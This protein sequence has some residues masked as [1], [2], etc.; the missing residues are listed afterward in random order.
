MRIG[1]LASGMDT[2]QIISD[3]MRVERMPLDK[4]NQKKQALEWQRDDYREMNSLMAEMDRFIFDGVFRQSAYTKKTVTSSNESAVTVKNI[5]ATSNLTATISVAEIAET[6]YM[7]SKGTIIKTGQTL[8]PNA[9]LDS[10]AGNFANGLGANSFE[11]QSIK[12]DGTLGNKVTISFNP[13]VDSLNSVLAKINDSEAGV[14]AFYDPQTGKVSMSAKNTGDVASDAEIKLTGTF[15]TSTLNLH[16][17]N[18]TAAK[19][20]PSAGREGRNA[21]FTINGLST[22]RP[23][24]NFQINGFEYTLKSKT[25]SDATISSSTDIDAI[26]NT[27]VK[28]VDKYNE[29]IGK[30]NGELKEERYRDYQPL[31]DEQKEGMSEKQIELWEEKARSGMLRNDSIL[32]NGLNQFRLDMYSRVGIDGDE[33]N[34]SYDQLT[35]IGIKT[36]NN[37]LDRGKLVIEED[38]LKEAISK[39]PNAIYKLF[40]NDGPDF[41]SKGIARRLRDTIKDTIGKVEQRAGKASWTNQQFTLGRDLNDISKRVDRFQ[42]RL[43][44]IEDRYWRQFTEM[45]KAIQQSNSQSMYLMQQFSGGM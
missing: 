15:L 2:D 45:E 24:N 23:S 10:Q 26:F 4:L 39:D 17:D 28:F 1:G 35:E 44:L 40:T 32:A 25:T 20:N 41:Q 19:D 33:V 30:I 31:T 34:D 38:K 42:D 36:S 13:A 6:A 27:I 43:Q 37:Y 16:G 12:E 7:N 5:N 21:S 14:T 9:T 29:V 18:A 8:D 11:I 3:L 22:T